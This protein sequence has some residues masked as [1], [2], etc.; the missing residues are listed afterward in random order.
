MLARFDGGAVAAKVP[1]QFAAQMFLD[2]RFMHPLCQAS[3]GKLVKGTREGRFGRSLLRACLRSPKQA[4]KEGE[5]YE[6]GC[7]IKS[8]VSK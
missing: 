2:Q 6:Q 8:C 1:D 4:D 3:C 7:P 5:V